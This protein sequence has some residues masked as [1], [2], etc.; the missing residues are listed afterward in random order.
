MRRA[1]PITRR[2]S[3]SRR[4]SSCRTFTPNTKVDA[5]ARPR[6]Q[7]ACCDGDTLAEAGATRTP[8]R[9][10]AHL[11][12]V[13][14][15][16]DPRIIAGQGTVALEM[17][18]GRARARHAGG[19]G[20]RRRPDRR[21]AP[22]RPRRSSPTSRSSA[23]KS[24]GYSVDAP[25]PG[26]PAGD[27]GGDTIAEGIAVKRRRHARRSRSSRALVDGRAAGRARSRSSAPIVAADRDREDR[28][29]GRGRRRRSPRCSPIP[30]SSP[31]ARSAWC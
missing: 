23:S 27:G 4:P 1:S 29:R 17:L 20:R 21:H 11:V 5:H 2:G 12:F 26:R 15:Y 10:R 19:A 22:S 14:P 18:A 16:D 7:G 30:S 25:A 13:H 31:A 24:A 9:A 6:R 28:G 8:R 3:A